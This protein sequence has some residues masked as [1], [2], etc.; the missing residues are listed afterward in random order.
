M[1]KILGGY[2][3]NNPDT[4]MIS[5]TQLESRRNENSTTEVETFSLNALSGTDLHF[6]L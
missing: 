1:G 2:V 6:P 5:K 3:T 4:Y